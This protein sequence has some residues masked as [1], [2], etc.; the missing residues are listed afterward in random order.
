VK[1]FDWI[2]SFLLGRKQSVLVNGVLSSL[3]SV[4]SGI[5]QGTVL[6]PL[7]FIIF[8]NDILDEVRS[9]GYLFADDTKLVKQI[10]NKEDALLLQEDINTLKSSADKWGMEFNKDKCHI[11]SIGKEE[12]NRYN[13]DYH[14]GTDTIDH[15][16]DEKD[17]EVIVSHDLN[18]ETHID[19]KT[20]LANKI[21]CLI[22][23]SFSFLDPSSFKKLFLRI[24]ETSSR[25]CSLSMVT[26]FTASYRQIRESPDPC[27]KIGRWTTKLR[28]WRKT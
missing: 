28:V 3:G 22:R 9:D 20:N 11:I 27:N 5:P 10:T 26:L 2:S 6:G 17:L 7:L 4:L 21:V 1:S 15:V 12:N 19:N 13:H 14:I 24:R 18:F 8:I 23:R 25:I 16:F